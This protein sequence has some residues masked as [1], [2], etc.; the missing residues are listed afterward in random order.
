MVLESQLGKGSP[1]SWKADTEEQF[2]TLE[3]GNRY[4]TTPGA[5]ARINDD[6]RREIREGL[7]KRTKDSFVTFPYSLS[8]SSISTRKIRADAPGDTV[9]IHRATT[10]SLLRFLLRL[11]VL[12]LRVE[13]HDACKCASRAPYAFPQAR[14]LHDL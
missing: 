4:F 5:V 3:V 12:P 14:Q 8:M 6:Y 9:L 2:G 13:R 7:W 10:S 1:T 11:S